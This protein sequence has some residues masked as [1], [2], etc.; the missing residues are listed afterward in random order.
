MNIYDLIGEESAFD[1]RKILVTA[2]LA[3]TANACALLIINAAAHVPEAATL[4]SFVLFAPVA[5]FSVLAARRTSH[6]TNGIIESAL[7]RIRARLVEKI[8]RT[9]FERRERIGSAELLDRITENLTVISSLAPAMGVILQSLCIFVFGVFY[10]LWL[11]PLTFAILVPIQFV[12]IQIY[13]SHTKRTHRLLKDHAKT[14]IE[15]LDTLMDLLKGAKEVRLNR[16]RSRDLL[17]DFNHNSAK[18]ADIAAETN[19]IFDDSGLFVTMNLY[20]LLGTI[21]FVL[22]QYVNMGPELTAKIVAS[23]LFLWGSVHTGIG[24]Y[25]AFVQSN[26]AIDNITKLEEKLDGLT[27]RNNT[28]SQS[29]P[30]KGKPGRVEA[31]AVEYEYPAQEGE[32]SFRI[33]PIDLVVDPGELVFIVGGNG[34]GKSTLLKVLTGLYTPTDGILQAN[35]IAVLPHDAESYR[36]MISVIFADFHLFSKAYGLL[37]VEPEAVKALLREMQIEDKT[38]FDNGEF[39]R[40]N[41]STGQ[42]KRL[43]MIIAHLDERPLF[44][45]DEWA[46][47][48][49]PEFRKYFYECMLPALK[50]K[51]KTIIAVSHDDRYFHVADQVV[52]MEYGTIRS[53]RAKP[54]GN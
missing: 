38:S 21:V 31:I 3:G 53:I 45:L 40:Q 17:D 19:H 35:G 12:A 2:I 13:R 5:L 22:P 11:S 15:F 32:T 43:A 26:E 42:K 1:R 9:D 39:T 47:D 8:E 14:R 4:R 7:C 16:A 37:E 46:A 27:P 10:L 54:P 29:D 50:R 48:Q 23:L 25:S 52:T 30:W 41:L 49:D 51:G 20:V 6:R 34:S 24:T 36:E 44:V 33:G 18:L 28:K